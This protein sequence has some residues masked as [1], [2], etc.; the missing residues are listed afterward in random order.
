MMA[1]LL[2]AAATVGAANAQDEISNPRGIV[3]NFDSANLGPVLSE[4]GLVWQQRATQDGKPYIAA[5]VGGE[6][7]ITLTPTACTGANN[8]N[9]IGLHTT[10][11]ATG[12]GLNY[13]TVLAFGQKYAFTSVMISSDATRAAISRYDIADFGIPRG[14]IASSLMNF[15]Y[16]AMQFRSE[17]SSGA[18]TVS[19]K[20]YA[21]D[22]SAGL[23]NSR[24][25]TEVTGDEATS[26]SAHQN[27]MRE[28]AELINV[29]FSEGEAPRNKISN[30]GAKN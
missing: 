6:L 9:C 16:L 4:L 22:M 1:G 12:Q 11:L 19:L 8:T 20:G 26:F 17:L 15:V 27:A 30:L 25:L 14:N 3:P 10:S 23:L 28:S 7:M 5:S 21:E 2:A 13:Q 24:A 29:L 18:N